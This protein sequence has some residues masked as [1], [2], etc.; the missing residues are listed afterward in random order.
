LQHETFVVS[1]H[2]DRVGVRLQSRGAGDMRGGETVSEGVPRGAVQAAPS[3][4]PVILL[5]D[6]QTTGG[7]QVPA[8]VAAADLWRVAQ[9]RPGDAVRFMLVTLDEALAAL[10][11]RV[12]W[13]DQ[14][15]EHVA[16]SSASPQSGGTTPDV[17][18]LM[19]G[20]AEW[21]EE[22]ERDGE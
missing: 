2:A 9:L 1:P 7:Y 8:V 4:E 10:R 5:A 19:R 14:L 12:A 22:E 11:A 15:A 3:G 20:F 6:H 21:S 13:L 17:A 16:Q 18:L